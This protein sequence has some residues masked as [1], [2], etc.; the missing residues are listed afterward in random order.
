MRYIIVI[1]LFFCLASMAFG[2]LLWGYNAFKQIGKRKMKQE[3]EQGSVV[4]VLAGVA[5]LIGLFFAVMLSPFTIVD[6]GYVGV[7]TTFGQV[8]M[9][10]LPE[11]FHWILPWSD[12]EE[13]NVKVQAQT[14]NYGAASADLQDVTVA[15][16]LNYRLLGDR[17]PETFK[18]VGKEYFNTIVVPAAAETL[19]AEIALH[20]ASEILKKRPQIKKTIQEKLGVWLVKYGVEVSELS[21]QNITF[22]KEYQH[23]IEKKQLEEQKA[24]QKEYELQQAVKQAE[25]VEAAAKGEANATVAEAEGE[26]IAMKLRGEATAEFNLKVSRSLTA[27]LLTLKYYENWDGV[28]PATMLSNNTTPLLQLPSR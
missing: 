24:L 26:A 15:M 13:W 11:G 20:N 5:L 1:A 19:K 17:A 27:D 25:I 14:H 21:L 9:T 10:P 23:A 3:K 7:Q 6:P 28:L 12:V 18:N 8:N 2:V 22:S 4:P 16:T